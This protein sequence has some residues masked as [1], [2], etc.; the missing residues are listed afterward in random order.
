[1]RDIA[2][3]EINTV[4]VNNKLELVISN[5]LGEEIYKK[6]I[7]ATGYTVIEKIN[8]TNLAKGIYTVTVYFDDKNKQS[9]KILKL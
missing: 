1:M 8:M 2:T 7:Y 6:T 5:N 9:F 3:V 4:G